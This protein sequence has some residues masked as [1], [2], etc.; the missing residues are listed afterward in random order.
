MVLYLENSVFGFQIPLNEVAMIKKKP[1][2]TASMR[3]SVHLYTTAQ[4][5]ISVHLLIGYADNT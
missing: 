4:M 1:C 5:H 2:A 3:I